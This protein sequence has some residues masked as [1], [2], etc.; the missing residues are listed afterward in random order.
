[1]KVKGLLLSPHLPHNLTMISLNPLRGEQ[2]M[3]TNIKFIN[4]I[5][6]IS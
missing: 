3:E 6:H 4:G 5:T 1:L 2:V